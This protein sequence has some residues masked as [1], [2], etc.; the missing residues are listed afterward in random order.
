[1][2]LISR[3]KKVTSVQHTTPMPYLQYYSEICLCIVLV[4][5]QLL[6]DVPVE[7][8]DILTPEASS[9]KPILDLFIPIM[10][11]SMGDQEI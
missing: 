5:K 6:M 1:M 11:S 8:T 9:K 7:G 10:I 2:I 3:E 4:G